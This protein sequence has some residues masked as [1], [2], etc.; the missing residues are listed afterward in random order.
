MNRPIA[1]TNCC[2]V[3]SLLLLTPLLAAEPAPAS[4]PSL[5]ATVGRNGKA[6]LK[7]TV[8]GDATVFDVPANFE[9]SPGSIKR[10][11]DSWPKTVRIR[12][13]LRGLELFAAT[14]GETTVQWAVSS[15]EPG[16][17]HMSLRVG[18]KELPLDKESPYY[19]EVQVVA[20]NPKIPL[21]GGY[22]E[23][24]LPAKLLADN[25]AEISLFWVD[26]Y[27]E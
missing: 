18:E 2:F 14:A 26:F 20:P 6:P 9:I 10:L 23:V 4:K 17:Q 16:A 27:R 25:P 7:F 13:R 8:E 1:L 5:E 21:E 11:G 22:F 19:S 15:S 12:L 24:T 3:T